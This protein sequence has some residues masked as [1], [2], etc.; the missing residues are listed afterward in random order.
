MR[1]RSDWPPEDS[2]APSTKISPTKKFGRMRNVRPDLAVRSA[3]G[4]GLNIGKTSGGVQGLNA[5][6]HLLAFQR[7]TGLLRN[8]IEQAPSVLAEGRSGKSIF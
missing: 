2:G 4:L 3:L 5:L 1:S 7:G 8:Q 6:P